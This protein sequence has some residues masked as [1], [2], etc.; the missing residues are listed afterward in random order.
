M[1]SVDEATHARLTRN[2]IHFEVMVDP[3]LALRFRKGEAVPIE[4]VLASRDIFTDARKGDRASEEDLSAA[5]GKADHA[6]IASSIIKHGE[7][8]LTTEQ[9][10]RFADEKRRK[11][12]DIISR[13]GIDPKTKLPHPQQRILNAMEEARV[14]VD[15]FKPA[16]EQLKDVLEKIQSVIAISLERVEI[17]IIVPMSHAGKAS[18]HIREIA[19]LKKE[20]WRNDSWLAVIEIPAGIQSDVYSRINSVTGGTAEVR[21]TKEHKL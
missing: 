1:V 11:I 16:E 8:Q 7:L 21:I 5:F 15:P 19:P 9:R 18:S 4:D 17:S 2:G 3:D 14:S 6:T 20:E 13:Q 12:A 10:R